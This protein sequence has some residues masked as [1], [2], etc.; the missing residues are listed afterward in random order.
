MSGN[1]NLLILDA[2]LSSSKLHWKQR[3][4]CSTY[5]IMHVA[6][7]S[8]RSDV[9]QMSVLLISREFLMLLFSISKSLVGQSQVT[10]AYVSHGDLG[11]QP[12]LH[13]CTTLPSSL[14]SC[15]LPRALPERQLWNFHKTLY[16]SGEKS[17]SNSCFSTVLLLTHLSFLFFCY[18]KL[19]C[20]ISNYSNY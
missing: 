14:G 20:C 4:L 5:K 1:S 6:G 11:N 9:I 3:G 17:H 15:N 8:R 18:N 7:W 13:G 10:M 2:I 19:L 12:P 16:T